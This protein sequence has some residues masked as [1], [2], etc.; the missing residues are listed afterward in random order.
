[1]QGTVLGTPVYMSPEQF[2]G[3]ELDARSDVY[4]LGILTFEM[5]TGTLPYPPATTTVEWADRHL[6]ATPTPIEAHAVA[7]DLSPHAREV[8]MQSLEKLPER[9]P[10]SVLEFARGLIGQTELESAWGLGTNARAKSAAPVSA[11]LTSAPGR[12]A[13]PFV[14]SPA[15]AELVVPRTRSLSALLA[16]GCVLAAVGG[17]FAFVHRTDNAAGVSKPAP[18][19][20]TSEPPAEGVPSE[21]MRIVHHARGVV[22]PSAAIGAP[23]SHFARIEGNGMLTL[24]MVPGTVVATDVGPGPDLYIAVNPATSGPYRVEAAADHDHFL[25]VVSDVEGTLP[26][27]LD[28]FKLGIVRYVRLT[29]RSDKPVDVDAIGLYRT[30]PEP[31]H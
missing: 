6:N 22:D 16:I 19:P 1:M 7:H 23:D 13:A 5:L 14:E 3:L 2:V 30:E 8:L 24:E 29:N 9:R 11:P 20:S 21:W 26:L 10:A 18:P 15:D 28:Q 12:E 27:D 25:A 31:E 4:S 17:Y